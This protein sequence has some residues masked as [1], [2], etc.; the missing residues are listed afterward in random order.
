MVETETVNTRVIDTDCHSAAPAR[1]PIDAE[2]EAMEFVTEADDVERIASANRS[3]AVV[4][5]NVTRPVM[6]HVPGVRVTLD[7]LVQDPDPRA[8]G[9]PAA[10]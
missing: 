1:F 10:T 2:A 7:R 8:V 4:L 6:S 5:V 9:A 3:D